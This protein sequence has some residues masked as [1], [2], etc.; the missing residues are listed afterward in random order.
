M[1]PGSML[2]SGRGLLV[3]VAGLLP[4][5]Q[6]M[7]QRLE[8]DVAAADDR[9]GLAGDR[10]GAGGDSGSWSGPA[11]SAIRP[12]SLAGWWVASLMCSS[13]TEMRRRM[14]WRVRSQ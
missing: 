10:Y 14:C 11:P 13:V 12:C 4:G 2:A 1:S 7:G 3:L 5:L 9:D 8:G 6:H